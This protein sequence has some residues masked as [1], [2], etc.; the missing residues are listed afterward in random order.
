VRVADVMAR[1][2]NTRAIGAAHVLLVDGRGRMV[3]QAPLEAIVQA[4]P[5]SPIGASRADDPVT[6]KPWDT[7][8]SVALEALARHDADVAVVDDEGRPIGTI[9]IGRLLLLLH[10]EHVDDLLR[11]A[12][13]AKNHP[14]PRDARDLARSLRARTPWLVIGLFGGIAAGL[15][16]G[17]FE[18]A[19]QAEL[20][21]AYFIPLVVYMADAIGTQTEAMLVRA[22]AH[23][24][25]PVGRQLAAEV[26]LGIM[27]GGVLGVLS[28]AALLAAGIAPGV[29][30]VVAITLALTAVI[31]TQ[32]A[33]VL[34]L[35]LARLGADPALGSGPIA[36]VLQDLLS[37]A[38]YLG[39]ATLVLGV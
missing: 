25:V 22:L 6:V 3:G 8:E 38:V 11:M 16:V 24:A 33:S 37:V 36:T 30:A 31:S 29:A 10:E 17:R 18:E 39:V 15:V 7:A 26:L 13:V 21:L 12:G 28:G 32:V 1:M 19:L 35:A 20:T 23:G 14:A 4:D 2:R 27:I 34:P 9:P 5:D